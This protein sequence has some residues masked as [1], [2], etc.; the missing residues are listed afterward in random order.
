MFNKRF[1]INK[2]LC[3]TIDGIESMLVLYGVVV[4]G[5]IIGNYAI[6]RQK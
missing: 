3:Y 1:I 4:M 5:C 6:M 2:Q